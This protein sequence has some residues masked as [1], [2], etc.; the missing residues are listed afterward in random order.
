M[1]VDHNCETAGTNFSTTSKPGIIKTGGTDLLADEKRCDG[2]QGIEP[3]QTL[4]YSTPFTG[5]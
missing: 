5:N 1:R 4:N 3:L 2:I